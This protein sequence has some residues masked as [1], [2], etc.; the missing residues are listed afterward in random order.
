MAV[1]VAQYQKPQ[2]EEEKKDFLTQ[3]EK[4]LAIA[5]SAASIY[6]NLKG[7]PS[8]APSNAIERRYDGMTKDMTTTPMKVYG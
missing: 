1:Q 8:S 6:G 4:P 5:G 7:S 3:I 2:K